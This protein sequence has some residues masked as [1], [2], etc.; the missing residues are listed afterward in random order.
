MDNAQWLASEWMTRF[1]DVMQTM[2]DSKPQTQLTGI[3]DL[4]KAEL[5]WWRQPF[6]NSPESPFWVGTQEQDWTAV[7]QSVLLSAG[8]ESPSAAEIRSTWIEILQQSMGSLAEKIGGRLLVP[9][10]CGDG[11]ESDIERS[12]GRI[13]KVE[14]EIA[15]SA[16]VAFFLVVN[17]GL[18]DAV[19]APSET[20]VGVAGEVSPKPGPYEHLPNVAGSRTFELLLDVELPVTVSFG[21]ATLKINQALNLVSGSLIELNRALTDPVELL[22][23]DCM[24]ARGEVVVV[25]GNY[26]VRLTEIV[27]HKERLQQGRRHILN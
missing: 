5:L 17:D 20:H 9:V 3:G 4:P 26:G 11:T 19:S 2:A 18:A 24:I 12:A 1:V 15:D 13:F 22:V 16:R 10:T 7:G 27:S 8:V 6:S 23:N 14:A 21:R 25:E